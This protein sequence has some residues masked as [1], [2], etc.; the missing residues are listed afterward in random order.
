MADPAADVHAKYRAAEREMVTTEAFRQ[1]HG[2]QVQA[3][4]E[5]LDLEMEAG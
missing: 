2:S 1:R 5:R 3:D 4:L